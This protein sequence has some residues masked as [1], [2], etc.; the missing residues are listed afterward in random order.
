ML[1]AIKNL[2]CARQVFASWKNSTVSSISTHSTADNNDGCAIHPSRNRSQTVILLQYVTKATTDEL[3]KTLYDQNLGAEVIEEKRRVRAAR[4]LTA[5][6]EE[7]HPLVVE[8]PEPMPELGD[9]ESWVIQSDGGF[10][11]QRW[12]QRHAACEASNRWERSNFEIR[13]WR[14]L[15]RKA[16]VKENAE[17]TA[18]GEIDDRDGDRK[19]VN[20]GGA[21]EAAVQAK[22][23]GRVGRGMWKRRRQT[24]TAGAR[25]AVYAKIGGEAVGP[26]AQSEEAGGDRKS[27]GGYEGKVLKGM[28]G[29]KRPG[30]GGGGAKLA[31]RCEETRWRPKTQFE[32]R[33][34]S[35]RGKGEQGLA[36]GRC[37]ISRPFGPAVVKR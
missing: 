32:G 11:W 13:G 29:G 12:M 35:G 27:C 6:A 33:K 20:D 24:A 2:Y 7:A 25:R 18:A 1:K 36:R 14:Q 28:E 21:A 10:Q 30:T 8:M 16:L 5:T 31:G 3:Y 34:G 26:T 17:T 9:E 15:F 37:K 19:H 4:D 23:A 22:E